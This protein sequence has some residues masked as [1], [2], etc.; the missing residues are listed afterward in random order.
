MGLTLLEIV[1]PGILVIYAEITNIQESKF[2]RV[3]NHIAGVR[4]RMDHFHMYQ[5]K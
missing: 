4:K 2:Y 5:Y 3:E 1:L